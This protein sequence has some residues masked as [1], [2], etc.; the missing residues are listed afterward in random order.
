MRRFLLYS[1]PVWMLLIPAGAWF[2]LYLASA[3]S[4]HTNV[5]TIVNGSDSLVNATL[6]IRDTVVWR[7]TIEAGHVATAPYRVVASDGIVL[8][9][10]HDGRPIAG[11]DYND[12]SF[13]QPQIFVIEPTRIATVLAPRATEQLWETL[14]TVRQ[15]LS[16]GVQSVV[17]LTSAPDPVQQ[18]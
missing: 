8:T 10:E 6:S 17:D 15:V 2:L 14:D 9:A 7:G 3:P 5:A 11:G 12:G 4:C 18:H 13:G 16:C 1:I